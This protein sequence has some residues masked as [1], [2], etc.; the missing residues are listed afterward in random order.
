MATEGATT[1]PGVAPAAISESES[2]AAGSSESALAIE[3][4][5]AV[6]TLL[7]VSQR[8][9][10]LA[11]ESN[12][13]SK[14]KGEMGG[15]SA[16]VAA[17]TCQ[18]AGIPIAPVPLPPGELRVVGVEA[19]A[20]SDK[21]IDASAALLGEGLV[22]VATTAA[23]TGAAMALSLVALAVAIFKRANAEGPKG[24]EADD[25]HR[26][27]ESLTADE[28]ELALEGYERMLDPSRADLDAPEISAHGFPEDG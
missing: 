15:M 1:P 5:R 10:M 16:W 22:G 17:F 2:A 19:N 8:M 27:A 3:K 18:L 21:D 12:D 7:Q 11:M 23:S 4:R 6:Q 28:L 14:L 20:H 24:T 9:A 25:R 13:L 26:L